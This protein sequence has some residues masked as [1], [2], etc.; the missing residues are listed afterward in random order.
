M[1]FFSNPAMD[2]QITIALLVV[3]AAVSIIV[4]GVSKNTRKAAILFSVLANVSLLVNI[5]SRMFTYYHLKAL[6]YF[7]LFLWPILNIFLI[8]KY[9]KKNESH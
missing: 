9:L 7:A 5:G 1:S 4:Y 3:S 8:I 2:M 6:F